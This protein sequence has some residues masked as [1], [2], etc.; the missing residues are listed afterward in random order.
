MSKMTLQHDPGRDRHKERKLG[1]GSG[2]N[3]VT[4]LPKPTF[5]HWGPILCHENA[6]SP[7]AHMQTSVS[8]IFLG[9]VSQNISD[10]L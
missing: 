3:Y 8:W 9:T 1:A 10:I 5:I 2:S 6:P 7:L 4:F